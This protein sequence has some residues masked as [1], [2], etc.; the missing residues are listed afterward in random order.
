LA[1]SCAAIFLDF[2]YTSA[3]RQQSRLLHNRQGSEE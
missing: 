3:L 2:L 1:Q